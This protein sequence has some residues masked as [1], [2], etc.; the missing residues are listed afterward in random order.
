MNKFP[1]TKVLSQFS[2]VFFKNG[3]HIYVV[4]G[5][6]RDFLLG[7]DNHDYDF[8]TDATPQEVIKLFRKV[9]PTGI[10]HGTVTV[11][12]KDEKNQN[13]FFE[14][15]TFRTEGDY[16]DSRHPEDVRFV[17]SLEEDLKRRDFTINALAASLQTGEIFDYHNGFQDLNKSTI[18]CINNAETRF[19]EDALRMLR[20]CRFAAKL[21]FSIETKTFEAIK[22]LHKNILNVS[23]ERIKDEMD[24]LLLSQNPTNGLKLL[25]ASFLLENIIPEL[26]GPYYTQSLNSV[27][28]SSKNNAKLIVRYA[29]LFSNLSR[30][31]EVKNDSTSTTSSQIANK[32]LQRL[33]SSNSERKMI[34]H[35]VSIQHLNYMKEFTSPEVRRMVNK[36]GFENIET[37]VSLK[38]ALDEKFN[39]R[40]FQKR[41]DKMKYPSIQIQDLNING[42]DLASLGIKPGPIYKKLLQS[43]LNCVIDDPSENTKERLIQI[44]QEIKNN[45]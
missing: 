26:D 41:I 22:L 16:K 11:I 42:K 1:I 43:L 44:V 17:R 31:K 21:N 39:F 28:Q 5:A 19:G 24:R 34:C 29:C 35:L 45:S 32:I 14:V 18:R 7:I 2:E 20:A 9:I 27:N 13:Q 23:Q 25:K 40:D 33:K 8:T 4:G 36:I 37:F 3:F 6:V 38:K 10:K 30:D 12:F 15:T